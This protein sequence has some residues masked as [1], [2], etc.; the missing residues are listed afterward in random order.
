MTET[1]HE[2]IHT[3]TEDSVE[4]R[5]QDIHHEIRE[6]EHTVDSILSFIKKHHRHLI[7][8]G[9]LSQQMLEAGLPSYGA[10]LV[11]LFDDIS[12]QGTLAETIVELETLERKQ[13]GE[14]YRRWKLFVSEAQAIQKEAPKT[15]AVEAASWVLGPH[16]N[17]LI[18]E[19]NFLTQTPKDITWFFLQENALPQIK[20]IAAYAT[21]EREFVAKA[22]ALEQQWLGNGGIKVVVG[23]QVSPEQ[24]E[25]LF[26]P[27]GAAV[28]YDLLPP[29]LQKAVSL[30]SLT[31]YRKPK[32]IK[33][34][35]QAV[36][37]EIVGKFER[38]NRTMFFLISEHSDIHSI[39]QTW[40][41]E[42]GHALIAGISPTDQD[43]RRQF[44]KAVARSGHLN[45]EYVDDIYFHYGI[46]HGLEDDFADNFRLFCLFPH[47]L[48]KSE[49]ERFEA[50]KKIFAQYLPDVSLEKMREKIYTLI[51][52]VETK[53]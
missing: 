35:R 52:E 28:L 9:I 21:L 44:L 36:Q 33:K 23:D 15:D 50:M 4:K 11:E 7:P 29:S 25:Q 6:Q 10:R 14:V 31:G 40:F 32:K 41:H 20:H 38:E 12:Y 48:Q 30:I 22:R 27:R 47:E 13:P 19:S 49:P 2:H 43:I 53:K 39:L 37:K 51:Q 24:V 45:Q 46:V 34:R 5:F 17:P 8:G 1:S 42:L 18:P 16:T 26:G 3:Q